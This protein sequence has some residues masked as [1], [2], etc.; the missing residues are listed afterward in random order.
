[1]RKSFA[2]LLW[3]AVFT[4][5]GCAILVGLGLWQLQRLA[6]KQG[7]IAE[8]EARATMA[9]QP[10]PAIG[11]WPN[12]RPDSYEYRHVEL[13]GTFEN[14]KEA[15]IFRASGGGA[16]LQQPGYVVLT[17][18]RLL[19]GAYVIVNRGFAPPDRPDRGQRSAG[20]ISGST[21]ISGLMRQPE[22]RNPFTPLDDPDAGH[23]FTRDPGLI[24]AHFG[25]TPAAPFSIDADD[26]PVPGGWP[27]GGATI[28][29]FPNNHLS[30]AFTW[31][32]LAFALAGVFAAYAWQ[33][34]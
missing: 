24:A 3:P 33:N 21:C 31:F 28:L 20:D 30:Y 26:L 8:I 13:C 1:M 17:P 32:G 22:P 23:Y 12:L 19:S 16:G 9:P 18:L 29:A 6:W 14:K 34:R 15:L 4:C 25:L 7:L 11:E 5:V 27:K 10:L 2:K